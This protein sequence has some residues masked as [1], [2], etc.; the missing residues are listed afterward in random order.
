MVL[1]RGGAERNALLRS[2]GVTRRHPRTAIGTAAVAEA[3]GIGL[4][5]FAP[6]WGTLILLLCLAAYSAMVA[7]LGS[8]ETCGCFGE[9]TI[10]LSRRGTLVRNA[11]LGVLLLACLLALLRGSRVSLL[12]AD[13]IAFAAL[14][15]SPVAGRVA[16]SHLVVTLQPKDVHDTRI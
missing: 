13:A 5:A 6:A 4:L 10:D 7:R 9:A 15:L 1:L 3:V 16:L 14:A 11:A 2:T 12:S 8:N